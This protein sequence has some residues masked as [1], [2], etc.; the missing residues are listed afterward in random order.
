VHSDIQGVCGSSRIVTAL[1]LKIIG[2]TVGRNCSVEFLPD[3]KHL[4][5]AETPAFT[6]I[7]SEAAWPPM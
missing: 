1:L 4:S 7:L 5:V 3:A 2:G 6:D